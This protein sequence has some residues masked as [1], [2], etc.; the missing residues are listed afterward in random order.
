MNLSE[1]AECTDS[2]Y[3]KEHVCN[4][5][6]FPKFD[7]VVHCIEVNGEEYNVWQL[8]NLH[9]ADETEVKMG[10]AEFVGEITYHSMIKV[11]YCPFC[12]ARLG[13]F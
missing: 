10:E 9:Y 2:E 1:L 8:H 3:D 11:N 7:R 5:N 6:D 4:E 13:E 12:G